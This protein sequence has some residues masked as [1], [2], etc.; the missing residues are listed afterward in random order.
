LEDLS[1]RADFH[2]ALDAVAPPAPWLAVVVR[3]GLRERRKRVRK[4]RS[5]IQPLPRPTW[6]LPAVAALLAIAIVIAL[7]ASGQLARFYRPIPVRPPQHGLAAPAGCP[8]WSASQS[9]GGAAPASDKMTSLSVGWANGAL[10]TTDGGAQ[11]QHLAPTDM[12]SDAPKGTDTKAYP[13]GYVDYFLDSGH[14]WLAYSYPSPSSCF[15]HVTV[16]STV[17][18]GQS[19]KRS[20]PVDAAVQAD[21]SLQLQLDFVDAQHG[22]LMVLGEGR[23]A[24]DW[25]VYTTTNGG[26]DWQ[27]LS[28]VPL[29]SSFCSVEF[30]SRTV[31]FLGDCQNTSGPTPHLTVTR[32]GGKTWGSITLPAPLG[33]QFTVTAPVFFNQDQG[34]IRITAQTFSGNTETPSD[35][36]AVTNDGGRTWGALPQLSIPGYAQAFGFIDLNHF[37]AIIGDGKGST[38]SIYRTVDGGRTWSAAGDLPQMFQSYPEVT[39]VDSQHG[40]IDEPS[41][42]I[43]DGPLAFLSTSDG[44]RMWKDLHPQVS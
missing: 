12:L 8:G 30:I 3:D 42:N 27:F 40:F 14:A 37:L 2:R 23:I 1:L 26:L 36:L 25:F 43:G 13:P 11:W 9:G 44:G 39:F 10:R 31:G 32:D 29:M 41:Q 16:F 17:D 21:S 6:L 7:V 38:E 22:W 35:Y 18:G 20:R 4:A 33:T 28:Q 15:D 34:I 5:G 19:W 24:P